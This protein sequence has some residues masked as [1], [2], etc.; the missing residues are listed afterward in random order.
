MY[1]NIASKKWKKWLEIDVEWVSYA[2]NVEE[3]QNP[4]IG[5]FEMKKIFKPLNYNQQTIK[6]LK[7]CKILFIKI[8][9]SYMSKCPGCTQ[10][11]LKMCFAFNNCSSELTEITTKAFELDFSEF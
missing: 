11:N 1:L 9:K 4:E 2:V 10:M 5:L 7:Q 3:Q 6:K 8:I